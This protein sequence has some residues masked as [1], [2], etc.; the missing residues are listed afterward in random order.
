MNVPYFRPSIGEEERAAVNGVLDS[1]WLTT[2]YLTRRF[3]AEFAEYVGAR[4]AV[5]VN[6]CTAALHLALEAAGV[7]EGDSVLVPTMTFAATAEVVRYLGA[8]PVLVD[9]D[10]TTLCVDPGAMRQ[11]AERWSANGRLKAMMPMHYGGQMADV[12]R[13]N[14][15]AE[16]FGLSVIEDAAHTLPAY[17]E[18]ASGAWHPVGTTAPVTCFSF[19]ANKCI[20]TGEGGMLVTNDE[21]I[22]HRA[23]MMSLHGL[24]KNAWNRFEAKGSWYYEIVDAGFKYNLTDIAAA[25]GV[26]QLA[27]ADDFWRK[28]RDIAACYETRLAEWADFVELPEEIEGRQSSWHLYPLRLRLDRLSIDRAQFI[29]ELKHRGITCSVHW[30]PLHLHPYYRRTY[31]YRAD[32]FPVASAVW[33][34]LVS[35]PIFPGMREEEVEHVC[36]SIGE[37]ATA[38]RRE[39]MPVAVCA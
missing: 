14:G 29:E 2:G 32:D 3:E 4:H 22:A 37:V 6:S 10:P 27:K 8:H 13:L 5:A 23:Q 31:G 25:I 30:M 33:P 15:I 35:L 11:A 21:Q 20:T 26:A 7:R 34:R 18:D 1:G 16:E 36:R 17:I 12:F 19:Y 24:S 38:H 9:C 39:T 28:R